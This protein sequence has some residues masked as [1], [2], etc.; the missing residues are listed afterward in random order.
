[1]DG[2]VRP[3]E[4]SAQWGTAN[5]HESAGVSNTFTWCSISSKTKAH[6]FLLTSWLVCNCRSGTNRMQMA[7]LL[8]IHLSGLPSMAERG[9]LCCSVYLMQFLLLLVA[10]LVTGF[11]GMYL[12]VCMYVCV[13]VCAIYSIVCTFTIYNFNRTFS[14]FTRLYHQG[15]HSLMNSNFTRRYPPIFL[16]L[17][18]SL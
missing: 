6:V 10:M 16:L 1:M 5:P 4:L 15:I 17:T 13:C 18:V 14:R 2:S 8:G 11:W 3:S 7:D 12:Y 9:C